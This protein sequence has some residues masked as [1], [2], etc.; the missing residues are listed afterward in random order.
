MGQAWD[1]AEGLLAIRSV[2]AKLG[3]EDAPCLHAALKLIRLQ[4]VGV[5]EPLVGCAIGA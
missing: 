1:G 2:D 5:P 3:T 4:I